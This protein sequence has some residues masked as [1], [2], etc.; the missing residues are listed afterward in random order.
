MPRNC[1]CCDASDDHTVQISADF[2]LVVANGVF[3]LKT[4]DGLKTVE[5]NGLQLNVD[6]EQF[7]FDP[8]TG[9]LMFS[10]N[11]DTRVKTL[12]PIAI[13][14][15]KLSLRISNTL[16]IDDGKLALNLIA[17]DPI[18][19]NK[20]NGYL[21]FKYNP[22]EFT[23]KDGQLSISDTYRPLKVDPPLSLNDYKVGL[24]IG[25]GLEVADQALK[26]NAGKGLEIQ[27]GKL[28]IKA[29]RGF[30]FSDSTNELELL[31]G[32]GLKFTD[33]MVDLK[34]IAPLEVN[35]GGFLTVKMG[36]GT[37]VDGNGVSL[38][39]GNGLRFSDDGKVEVKIR[40]TGRL[41]F[42]AGDFLVA[43]HKT[44]K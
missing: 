41:S 37:A 7:M 27:N 38:K 36:P 19:L 44:L 23:V 15:N 12:P 35:E 6:E 18:S 3:S 11:L 43:D 13:L 25:N 5:D 16:K 22:A 26:V 42:D 40:N 33:G 21:T 14:N 4:G 9:A 8:E 20:N 29:G 1:C 24:N 28:N 39:L 31:I 10:E 2:P 17:V 34:I 30:Q 32:K